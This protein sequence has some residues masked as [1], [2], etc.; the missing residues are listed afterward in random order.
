VISNNELAGKEIVVAKQDILLT[1]LSGATL[2]TE[3][4]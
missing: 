3:G 2:K 4:R 1:L